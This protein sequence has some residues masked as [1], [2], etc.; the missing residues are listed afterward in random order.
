MTESAFSGSRDD[1][2]WLAGLLEGE[3]TFD[4]HRG[5]YPRVRLCMTDRDV[6]ERAADLMGTS[7]RLSLRQAPSTPTW[8]A[9]L[10]GDRAAV[11]MEAVLPLMGARRSQRIAEVLAASAYYKGHDRKTLPGPSV[12][13]IA[14]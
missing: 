6:V 3:G 7:V 14:A 11:I 4:A 10:S 1:L 2:I 12:T 5:R 9:E 13:A 8:N